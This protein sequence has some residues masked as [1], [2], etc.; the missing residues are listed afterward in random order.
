[1][2]DTTQTK[3]HRER[4]AAGY[5]TTEKR[6]KRERFPDVFCFIPRVEAHYDYPSSKAGRETSI[7]KQKSVD[8]RSPRP[9]SR[10]AQMHN[11]EGTTLSQYQMVSPAVMS[12]G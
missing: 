2:E 12:D 11:G 3:T 9:L 4:A 5:M 7:A 8:V 6:A 10:D 1:M